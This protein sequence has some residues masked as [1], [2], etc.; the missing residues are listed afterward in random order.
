MNDEQVFV[1]DNGFFITTPSGMKLESPAGG[2]N[3]AEVVSEE[4]VEAAGNEDGEVDPD[5]VTDGKEESGDAF[6]GG[7][8][9]RKR[10]EREPEPE[11]PALGIG[12]V[13]RLRFFFRRIPYEIDC[14]ILDRF[15]PTRYRNVDLTPQM[16]RWLSRSPPE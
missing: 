7:G 14:Q 9:R 16:G 12:Q 3:I 15:N 6:S 5:T 10:R 4:E 11:E 1:V 13:I 8:G 2:G